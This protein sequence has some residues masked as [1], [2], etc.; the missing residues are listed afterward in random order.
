MID[1]SKYLDRSKDGR[2]YFRINGIS[3]VIPPLRERTGEIAGLAATPQRVLI[4]NDAGPQ[5]S[6][7]ARSW[8]QRAWHVEPQFV[9]AR[10]AAVGVTSAALDP[11]TLGIARWLGVVAAGYA[12]RGPVVV[13]HAAADCSVDAIDAGGCH[14]GGCLVPGER[15]MR[16]ALFAQTSAIAAAALA[17][18]AALSGGF[19]VN[20]AGAVQLM[21]ADAAGLLTHFVALRQLRGVRHVGRQVAF[22]TGGLDIFHVQHRSIPELDVAVSGLAGRGATLALV[23]D[24]AAKLVERMPVVIGMIGERQAQSGIAGVLHR[25]MAA[26]AAVHT[27]Q[28]W[29]DELADLDGNPRRAG[30][31][32]R[33]GRSIQLGFDEFPLPALPLAE[34][35]LVVSSNDQ[36]AHQQTERCEPGI[37]LA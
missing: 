32:D 19:G 3:I 34:L 4:A 15:S 11:T 29:Q 16:D 25:D 27:I 37:E 12:A 21:A 10:G 18:P 1:R 36:S 7:S 6:A 24:G 17:D 5:F 30:P 8:L 26:C 31:L 14:V 23:A 33:G 9:V 20:T 13:A 22:A 2:I 35:V 28:L